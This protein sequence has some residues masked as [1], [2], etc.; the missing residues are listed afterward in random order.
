[1]VTSVQGPTT[2]SIVNRKS[3][4]VVNMKGNRLC[5]AIFSKK[6][7]ATQVPVGHLAIFWLGQAGF[8][9]KTPANRVIYIDP[10]LSD[11]RPPSFTR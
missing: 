2:R 3:L 10:Y 8:V 4:W 1:V 5:A 11:L 9:Y 7:Q 6:V